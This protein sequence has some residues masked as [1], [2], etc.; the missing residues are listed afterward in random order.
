M[1]YRLLLLA[2]LAGFVTLLVPAQRLSGQVPGV[3]MVADEGEGAKYWPRWRGPSGQGVAT[4]GGYPDTWS[5]TEN[6]LW[7]APV[8]GNGNSS[9][10]V[11]GDHVFL[12]TAYD[13]GR[14]VSVLAYRRS[15]GRLLW[16][17]DAPE[18]PT[19]RRSHYKNG[20][21]SATPSTDGEARLCVVRRAGA[22]RAR[23]RRKHSLAARPWLDGRVSWRRRIRHSSTRTASSSTR[24]SSATPSSPP[25]TRRPA[26]RSGGRAR[27]ASVGWGTPIA[28]RVGGHDEVIVNSQRQVQAYDPVGGGELWRC[29][30]TSYEVIPT[31]VCRVWHG[32]LLI[33]SRRVRRWQSRR[34]E[35]AT[36][37]RPMS[38]GGVLV[39]PRSCHRRSSTVSSSTW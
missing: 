18:G 19:D 34:A 37:R 13:G 26:G 14:R 21:A 20:H 3:R 12:T 10:I 31:P 23:F 5:A 33:G 30:G 8:P 2:I 39:A 9:P 38:P 35:A 15:D 11:W 27:D 29:G 7:K 17:T 1:T 36:C 28:I 25:S 16:E 24:I 32:V 4:G 22:V 6:V